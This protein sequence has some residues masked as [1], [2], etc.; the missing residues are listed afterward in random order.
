MTPAAASENAL[1]KFFGMRRNEPQMQREANS[2][3]LK[4]QLDRKASARIASAKRPTGAGRE[5]NGIRIGKP[6]MILQ[7]NSQSRPDR[8]ARNETR[9]GIGA[10]PQG[11]SDGFAAIQ[12]RN[13]QADGKAS[14]PIPP[15][16]GTD[17]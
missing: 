8:K 15:P 4:T 5:A 6:R 10:N 13:R 12:L 14:Q 17:C 16:D 9:K 3:K 2:R 1:G 11:T 7:G